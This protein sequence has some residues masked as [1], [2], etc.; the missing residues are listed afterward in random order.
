MQSEQILV[1]DNRINVSDKQVTAVQVSGVQV[2]N[3]DT[4]NAE[5]G[6][7][8]FT[9]SII[10]NNITTPSINSTIVSRRAR[11]KYTVT[12]GA[13][14]DVPVLNPVVPLAGV[15]P[16]AAL[17]AFPLQS[18]CSN[19][20]VILNGSTTNLDQRS[21]ISATQRRIPKDYL[22]RQATECPC[23]A[24]NAT[25]LVVDTLATALTGNQPL[26]CYYNSDGTT[27][28][29]FIPNAFNVPVNHTATYSVSEPLLIS[30]FSIFEKETGLALVNTLSIQFNYQYLTDMVS[31]GNAVAVPAGLTVTISD[32]KLELEYIQVSQDVKIPPMVSYPYE[33]LVVFNKVQTAFNCNAVAA[34]TMASDTL[35]FSAMPDLLYIFARPQI[36]SRTGAPGGTPAMRGQADSFMALS[37]PPAISITL[38][39]RS[40]LLASA[41][42]QTLYEIS[43]R[44][45]YNSSFN[46]WAYQSGSLIIISPTLDLGLNLNAGDLAVGQNG[47]VN[48]Q[49]S[50]SFSNVN[51]VNNWTAVSG[52]AINY[53]LTPELVIIP[54]FQ[55]RATLSPSN[56]VFSIADLSESE[57]RHL[58][59]TADEE[60]GTK[61]SSESLKPSIQGGSLFG[62][63]KR[64][65]SKVAEGAHMVGNHPLTQKL[66]G[67]GGDSGGLLS[68][69]KL[70]RR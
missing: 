39:N 14:A 50:A 61:V 42:Q 68:G 27:R 46:D 31:W 57:L 40:G 9:S 3:I 70:R 6:N 21:V 33:N 36:T 7:G 65:L 49:I 19:I 62:S 13:T 69:G 11:I 63:M 51:Y 48:F 45:G 64:I 35:R 20:S 18:V 43:C 66:A 67:M 15:G 10:F 1:L 5:G 60:S 24:D 32:P 12:V 29:S 37:N 17:R 2:T 41:S 4:T 28:G 26:S 34:Q 59:R 16:A 54:V 53:I 56:C 55:G 23:M 8:S 22:K 47:S 38:G 44:N 25:C 52:A 58:L 30:P